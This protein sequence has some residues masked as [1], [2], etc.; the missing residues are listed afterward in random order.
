[1]NKLS[2]ET[3]AHP[4][5]LYS[6]LL[7]YILYLLLFFFYQIGTSLGRR[8]CGQFDGY[9]LLNFFIRYCLN[10]GLD[11]VQILLRYF[12][13]LLF[14]FF[15]SNAAQ[16]LHYIFLLWL[17]TV[18]YW[19]IPVYFILFIFIFSSRGGRIYLQWFIINVYFHVIHP[20]FAFIDLTNTHTRRTIFTRGTIF[21]RLTI[22]NTLLMDMG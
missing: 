22:Q 4:P 12:H 21:T 5:K 8:S 16:L 13:Q 1:M 9:I 3:L 15:F 20:T 6:S 7:L 2:S 18:R 10:H 11:I 14:N 17:Y 19:L